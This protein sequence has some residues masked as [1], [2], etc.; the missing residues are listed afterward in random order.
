MAAPLS[1]YTLRVMT[2]CA[3]GVALVACQEASQ[4]L[5]PDTHAVS[6]ASADTFGRYGADVL[7]SEGSNARL[8]EGVETF[9][10][11]AGVQ[12]APE[13]DV[14]PDPG[15]ADPGPDSDAS[16][17]LLRPAR[18]LP[19][20]VHSP[21]TP[22]VVENLRAI[23]AIDE[24]LRDDVFAKIGAS[25]MASPNTLS[26]FAGAH[27][28]A[29]LIP[30]AS[31]DVWT[32]FLEGDAGGVDPFSRQSLAALNGKTAAWA[33]AGTPSPLMSE[34]E[35]IEPRFGLVEYGTNDMG[36]GS[37]YGSAMIGFADALVSLV[38]TLI[39]RGIIPVLHTNRARLDSE[40]A[41]Q[42]VETYNTVIRGVAQGR[43]IPL[44][45]QFELLEALTDFGLGNDGLHM[46][47]YTEGGASRT[48]RF[49]EEALDYGYNSR[50]LATMETLARLTAVVTDG[51][52]A[53]D[54]APAASEGLGTLG[55]PFV[56]SDLP[57]SAMRSTEDS[58]QSYLDQYS[59][60]AASQDE[61]G[62]EHLYQLTLNETTR[63]RAMVLD[64]GE[65]DIDLHLLNE[66][67][68]TEGC[69]ARHDRLWEGTLGP[70]TYYFS[71][72]TFVSQ[73]VP[74]PGEY[75]FVLVPCHPDDVACD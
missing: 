19:G 41:N 9:E 28:D 14:S 59:G 6:Y 43:Q 15:E 70:G 56:I 20:Q 13:P 66:T 21:L 64:Q 57:F 49:H 42:W 18:Y 4:E 36:M 72:D 2:L 39:V 25:S 48:C 22:F 34:I 67:A 47:A 29:T 73:G 71:L 53:P 54:T 58:L 37:T 3:I 63:L 44:F 33:L 51:L 68:T 46:S 23:A 60:C 52:D 69:M 40:S 74:K 55:A 38:D 16:E 30:E 5:S 11:T 61:S 1:P 10:D 50:N 65:V 26:C 45:D 24:G 12:D 75:L 8:D 27:V 62:P 17:P 35:L 31:A 32:L 7:T